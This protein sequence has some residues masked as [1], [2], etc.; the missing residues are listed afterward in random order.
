MHALNEDPAATTKKI[1]KS[2]LSNTILIIV[3]IAYLVGGAFMFLSIESGVEDD[4][5]RMCQS[6]LM[7]QLISVHVRG[8]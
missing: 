1:V 2:I 7:S 5:M 6:R 8:V 4:Y 3:N